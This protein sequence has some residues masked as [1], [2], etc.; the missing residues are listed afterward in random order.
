MREP[1]VIGRRQEEVDRRQE[2]Q[3]GIGV[4]EKAD[5]EVQCGGVNPD[6]WHMV[7]G[8]AEWAGQ[9]QRLGLVCSRERQAPQIQRQRRDRVRVC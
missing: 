9:P 3:D 6:R 7:R 4:Q 1:E 2:R 5:V 8:D